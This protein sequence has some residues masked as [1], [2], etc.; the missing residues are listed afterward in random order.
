MTKPSVVPP[1]VVAALFSGLVGWSAPVVSAQDA[2]SP[3][4]ALEL[5]RTMGDQQLQAIGAV[6]PEQPDRYIAAMLFPGIQ[7][8]AVAATPQV[9]ALARQ[10]LDQRRYTELYGT[11][12]QAIVPDSK[13]FVQDMG[14]DG[15]TDKGA[16]SVDIIDKRAVK[17]LIFDGSPSRHQMTD[18]EYQQHFAKADEQYSR[19]LTALIAS[20]KA[21]AVRSDTK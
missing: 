17:Q 2:R 19:V 7:L 9:P 13:F 18:K 6:D 20:A 5:A 15:L 4:L 21:P 10:E 8:L 3:A 1:A 12:H 11:L 14:A 16:D